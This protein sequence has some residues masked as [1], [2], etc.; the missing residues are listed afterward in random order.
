M[1]DFRFFEK[2]FCFEFWIEVSRY[3]CLVLVLGIVFLF[4]FLFLFLD[5]FKLPK[6]SCK[7][8]LDF[9]KR[10]LTKLSLETLDFFSGKSLKLI[11]P[12]LLYK[13]GVSL[14]FCGTFIELLLFE[15]AFV[16]KPEMTSVS[17]EG[18][19]QAIETESEDSTPSFSSS[20][21][22]PPYK[23]ILNWKLFCEMMGL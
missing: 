2:L 22:S 14:R 6:S 15:K 5:S 16:S 3:C 17:N 10:F 11:I 4:E 19:W 12:L 20:S 13:T 1:Q 8:S 21:L 9:V 7:F 18:D 23:T